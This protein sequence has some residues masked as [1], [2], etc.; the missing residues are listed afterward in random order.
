VANK[1]FPAY[2]KISSIEHIEN[3]V[4]VRTKLLI[5]PTTPLGQKYPDGE[6]SESLEV[7][8]CVQP[9]TAMAENTVVSKAGQAL[10]HYKWADPQ[11]L[12]LAIG[13]TL[14]PGTVGYTLRNMLCHED[15]Q[16][17]LLGKNELSTKGLISVSSTVKGDGDVFYAPI[18]SGTN[19][20]DEKDIRDIMIVFKMHEDTKFNL[21]QGIS[22]ADVLEY[23]T[24][25]DRILLKCGENKFAILKSDFYYAS[26]SLMYTS[27]SDI[28]K[29]T[30][31]VTFL[32]K[33]PYGLLQRITCRLNETQQ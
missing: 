26:N 25:V 10:Y 17:P 13:A 33:S 32:E 29:G 7:Y 16:T 24:E 9:M 22:L 6:Y 15:L 14:T 3:R 11:F 20:G 12:D 4:A 18:Q 2:L 28:S 5:D 30:N 21:P 1:H 23:R 8:D 31:W 19:G 27:A